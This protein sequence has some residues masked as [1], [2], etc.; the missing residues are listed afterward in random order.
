MKGLVLLNG[1]D[2]N[3]VYL[4]PDHIVS[5]EYSEAAKN[6]VVVLITTDRLVVRDSPETVALR[7]V[8]AL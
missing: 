4:N 2:G 6:T 1:I 8:T 5:V 7:V 3:T